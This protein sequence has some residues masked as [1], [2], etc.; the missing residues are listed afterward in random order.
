MFAGHLGV[1][2]DSSVFLFVLQAAF[3]L[4]VE[5]TRVAMMFLVVLAV[6]LG[7]VVASPVPATPGHANASHEGEPLRVGFL[8]KPFLGGAGLGEMLKE[9][10][11]LIEDSKTKLMKAVR[12]LDADKISGDLQPNY[13]NESVTET[14][15]AHATILTKQEIIKDCIVDEDCRPG[16]YCHLS[17]SEYRCLPCEGEE[18]CTRDGECCEG[19]LCVWGQCRPSSKGRSGTICGTEQDCGLGL[20]CAVHTSLLLPVCTPLPAKGEQCQIQPPLLPL[21][22]WEL[23]PEVPVS[24][25]PCPSGLV[26]QPQSYSPVSVC[27]DPSPLTTRSDHPEAPAEDLSFFIPAEDDEIAYDGDL[28][29]PT[30]LGLDLSISEDVIEQESELVPQPLF[31]D[32]I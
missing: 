6:T 7:L 16:N 13:P 30:G 29:G 28:V 1:F 25:C 27:E 24:L 3:L 20:C 4:L 14:D 21:F 5:W 22:T 8:F 15:V 23:E 32:D 2:R 10:E 9:V 11:Q 26:C 17:G 19:R 31:T 18:T 12:E